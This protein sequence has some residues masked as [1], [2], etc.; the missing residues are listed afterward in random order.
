MGRG[1]T[2]MIWVGPMFQN[3]EYGAICRNNLLGLARAG[4]PVRAVI[5]GVDD[6]R[7][8]DPQTRAAVSRLLH[9]DVGRYPI[10]L[11]NYVPDLY[12]RVWFSK[13]VKKIC[14]SL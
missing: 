7:L 5:F 2:G 11:I 4:V 14:Y 12:R 10:G 6:R 8:L 13:I 9:T 3:S 1:V